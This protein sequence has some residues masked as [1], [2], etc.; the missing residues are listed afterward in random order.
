MKDNQAAK[1]SSSIKSFSSSNYKKSIGNNI[2]VSEVNSEK[3][4]KEMTCSK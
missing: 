1:N 4:K 2:F 3:S